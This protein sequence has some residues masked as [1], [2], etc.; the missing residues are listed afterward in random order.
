MRTHYRNGDE[1]SLQ[2]NGCDGC[3][4]SMINGH[5]CH[6]QGCPE[7]WKDHK[8]E[9]KECGCEFAPEEKGQAFCSEHCAIWYAGVGFECDC[10]SC[11]ELRAEEDTEQEMDENA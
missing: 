1:I 10:Q 9:C 5:L 8:T 6:E 2:G 7:A 3:S 4:P 11:R